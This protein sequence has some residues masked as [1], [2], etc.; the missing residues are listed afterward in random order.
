MGHWISDA[1][2]APESVLPG[3]QHEVLRDLCFWAAGHLEPDIAE[4]ILSS[5][6]L[7]LPLAGRPWTHEDVRTR[8][9]SAYAK[10]VPDAGRAGPLVDGSGGMGQSPSRTL[11]LQSFRTFDE[12]VETEPGAEWFVADMLAPGCWTELLGR[13]KEGKSTFAMGMIGA[14]LEG[15]EFLGRAT[16]QTKVLYLT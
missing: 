4:A 11:E 1:L 14:M 12:T 15:S 3:S 10:R 9:D 5:W 13:M 7:R 6:A 16:R 8:L 2:E